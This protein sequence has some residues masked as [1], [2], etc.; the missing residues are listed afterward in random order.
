[1]QGTEIGLFG[2]PSWSRGFDS[3]RS[4]FQVL[5]ENRVVERL[6]NGE[7]KKP[8]TLSKI[9]SKNPGP[10]LLSEEDN[11]TGLV[12]HGRLSKILS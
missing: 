11:V 6:E 5:F 7:P 9:L 8:L 4:L 12:L 2:F 3:P 10:T 1:M